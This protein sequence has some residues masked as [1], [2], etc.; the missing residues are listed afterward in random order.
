MGMPRP[1]LNAPISSPNRSS[2][3]NPTTNTGVEIAMVD[4]TSIA[5]AD[6]VRGRSASS[7]P[8]PAPSASPATTP[9]AS[10]AASAEALAHEHRDRPARQ[11]RAPEVEVQEG[12]LDVVAVQPERR[13][14]GREQVAPQRV[15]QPPSDAHGADDH[16]AALEEADRPPAQAPQRWSG[17][18]RLGDGVYGRQRGT[19]SAGRAGADVP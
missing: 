18:A 2:S 13:A 3:P 1:R 19:S 6:A 11:V 7:R 12:P 9:P 4:S 5:R 17:G 16:A 14:L 10:S 15:Q 8:P